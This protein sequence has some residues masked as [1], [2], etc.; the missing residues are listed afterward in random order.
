MFIQGDVKVFLFFSK[1]NTTLQYYETLH[2]VANAYLSAD[3]TLLE[4]RTVGF[5]GGFDFQLWPNE[6]GLHFSHLVML[7]DIFS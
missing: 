5:L 4:P 6:D 7:A 3:K 1:G 2:L